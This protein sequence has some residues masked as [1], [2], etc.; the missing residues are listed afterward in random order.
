VSHAVCEIFTMMYDF[1]RA[2]SFFYFCL[3]FNQ[4]SS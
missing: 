4:W 1:A 2:W 3:P